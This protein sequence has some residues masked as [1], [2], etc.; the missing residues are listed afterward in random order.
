MQSHPLRGN[1]LSL[2]EVSEF[3]DRRINVF[4]IDDIFLVFEGDLLTVRRWFPIL[5][6]RRVIRDS[7]STNLDYSMRRHVELNG[8]NE[9]GRGS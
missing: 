7:C 9:F 1:H 4:W 5:D 3:S 6:G 8:S 2:D